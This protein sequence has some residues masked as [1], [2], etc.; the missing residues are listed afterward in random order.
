M[1]MT[2]QIAICIL[3]VLGI[4]WGFLSNA[5]AAEKEIVWAAVDDF[6]GPYAS[7]GEEGLR[8]LTLFLEEYKYQIGPYKINLVTRDTELKPAVGVRR[9][10]ELIAESKPQAIF[11][12]CSSAVQLAM[13]DIV[14]KTK[15]PIFW[16]DGWDTRLTGAQSNRYTFRWASSSYTMARASVSGFLDKYPNIKTAIHIEVDYAHGYDMAE[17]VGAVLKERGVRRIKTQYMP[18]TATDAS[19]FVTE[20]RDSGADLYIMGT[21]GKTF[22]TLLTQV[23]EFGLQKKMKLLTNAGTLNIL[24][25]LGSEILEGMYLADHWNHAIPNK[26]SRDFTEKF[27]KRW[28]VIPGDYG[29]ARYMECELML[30]VMKETGSADPKVIIPALEKIG[31]FDGPTGKESMAAW[32]HQIVHDFLLLRAKSPKE[33]KYEDDYVEVVGAGREYPKQGSK[34][35]EFDRTKETL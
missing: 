18:V 22:A 32:Q 21:Y 15:G 19:V 17:H 23:H 10:Q 31:E 29:A 33:K 28:G 27:K 35:Y 16:T 6:S 30:R 11:S 24:R 34:G 4:G 5:P 2:K 8:A 12:A 14:G 20:A 26:W 7:T 13:C 1:K 3:A 9:V 25:G